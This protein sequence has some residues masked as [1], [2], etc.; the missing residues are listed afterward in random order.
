MLLDRLKTEFIGSFLMVYLVGM[1]LIQYKTNS[2]DILSIGISSFLIYGLMLWMGVPQSGGHFN[3]IISFATVISKHNEMNDMAMYMAIQFL[4]CIF[5]LSMIKISVPSEIFNEIDGIT[6]IGFPLI[7]TN[8][9]KVLLLEMIG[10][11]F[12]VFAYYALV[13]EVSA[14]SYVYG[15]GLPAVLLLNTIFLYNKTGCSMNPFRSLAYTMLTGTFQNLIAYLIGPFVGGVGGA[16]LGT[17]MLTESVE[18]TKQRAREAELRK[19]EEQ[20]RK[21][22]ENKM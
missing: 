12:L 11:F 20:M 1:A 6:M 19:K 4:G 22:T 14:K 5:A 7:D 8:P 16:L 18:R 2:V 15:A 13:L 3:P 9:L 10:S 17:A 21:Q